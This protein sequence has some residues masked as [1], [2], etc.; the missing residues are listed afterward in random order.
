MV[1]V[2]GR[3]LAIAC[4]SIILDHRAGCE[5]V[6][7]GE[8]LLAPTVTRRLIEAFAARDK[9]VLVAPDALEALTDRA[10]GTDQLP[11][12]KCLVV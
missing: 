8:A 11:P 3:Q 10:A 12:S 9:P 2:R 1:E 6:A 7:A 4:S 5:I